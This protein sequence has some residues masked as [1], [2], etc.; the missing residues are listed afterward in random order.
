MKTQEK[1]S[2]KEKIEYLHKND[3]LSIVIHFV[4]V[5]FFHVA[6]E[7][8]ISVFLL[9]M[10]AVFTNFFFYNPS[11][12]PKMIF[13]IIFPLLSM[14]I[15][16]LL[17]GLF[18]SWL[19][20][21]SVYEYSIDINRKLEI[22]PADKVYKAKVKKYHKTIVIAHSLGMFLYSL[23]TLVFPAILTIMFANS[24]SHS[25]EFILTMWAVGTAFGVIWNLAG[26]SRNQRL[27]WCRLVK[28]FDTTELRKRTKDTSF[29][30]FCKEVVFNICSLLMISV[31][32]MVI[33]FNLHPQVLSKMNQILVDYNFLIIAFISLLTFYIN[34]VFKYSYRAEDYKNKIFLSISETMKIYE[35]D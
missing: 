16:G 17:F 30:Y 5:T 9:E 7:C 24:F 21:K 31:C 20:A 4:K 28:G 25:T 13:F 11:D 26:I 33:V 23:S 35:M 29:S 2:W 6:L 8:L 10:I 27:N 1:T 22:Q 34:K 18:S 15:V 32:V 3:Y 19:F 14:I 12:I